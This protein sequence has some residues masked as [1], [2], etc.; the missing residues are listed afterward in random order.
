M[1]LDVIGD[2]SEK[3]NMAQQGQA[4]VLPLPAKQIEPLITTEQAAGVLG[5]S[6][7]FVEQDR[8]TR[9]H[10]IPF[11]RVGRAVRYRPADLLAWIE[12]HVEREAA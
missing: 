1:V 11:V 4:A 3:V 6:L 2:T 8:T 7:Q 10:G 5:V 12:N 9:R